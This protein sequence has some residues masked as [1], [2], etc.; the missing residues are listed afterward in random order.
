MV[1]YLTSVIRHILCRVEMINPNDAIGDER[2]KEIM[3]EFQ[4]E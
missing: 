3:K 4:E 2:L 1:K